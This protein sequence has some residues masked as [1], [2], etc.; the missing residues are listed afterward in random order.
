MLNSK[1]INREFELNKEFVQEENI[2]FFNTIRKSIEKVKFK[3]KDINFSPFS[4]SVYLILDVGKIRISD[5]KIP[6]KLS[7]GHRYYDRTPDHTLLEKITESG[8]FSLSNFDLKKIKTNKLK[9]IDYE[10]LRG[11]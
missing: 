4:N 3:I 9:R 2:S 11:Y 8:R 1:V 5:H 10:N 7:K 6:G